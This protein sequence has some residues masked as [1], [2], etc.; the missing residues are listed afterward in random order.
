MLPTVILPGYLA[1][2][3]D[4]LDL[5]QKL[6]A[7]GT[8]TVVVPLQRKDWFVTLGGR[9]I[10]P[11]LQQLDDTIQEILK[12]TQAPQV[13]IV[14]H[15]AG[16]WISRIYM[17]SKPYCGKIWQAQPQVNTLISLG[18]PHTSQESWTLSNL[19]F[20]NDNYPGA[21]H[22]EVKYICVAGKALFGQK[23]WR[24][25]QWFTYSS[26]QTTCGRGEC[27]GDGVTPVTSAHLSGAVNLTLDNVWHSP[28]STKA[29]SKDSPYLWYGSPEAIKMWGSYL[30]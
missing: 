27:W 23:S 13:N 18:T 1:P 10:S 4:Y 30:A 2:A 12:R 8:E 26:Y 6:I 17:G 20:V 16:G 14:G 22:P 9:P 21:F 19:N 29:A 28:H 3:K 24:L 7:L 15:S 25:G 11:I 5:Q